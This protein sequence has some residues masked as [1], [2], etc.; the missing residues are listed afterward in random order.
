MVRHGDNEKAMEETVTLLEF[1]GG[2]GM[3]ASTIA[4]ILSYVLYYHSETRE[5]RQAAIAIGLMCA[6]AFCACTG[7]WI[8]GGQ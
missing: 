2:L 5:Q 4:V 6:G 1:V 8:I 7:L 3:I